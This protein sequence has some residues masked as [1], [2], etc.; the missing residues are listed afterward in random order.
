MIY[1]D[2]V[3]GAHGN[4][5][6]YV[7]N[8]FLANIEVNDSPFNDLGAA[9]NKTYRL[10]KKFE[11]WHYFDYHGIKTYLFNSK[12]VS[13]QSSPD[14]LL[15]LISV[16]LL[17]AA[18]HNLD[19]DMLEID[20][21]NKLNNKNYKHMLKTLI[22]SFFQ[23]TR[24]ADYYKIKDPTWPEIYSIADFENLPLLI[25]NECEQVFGLLPPKF[26]KEFPNCPRH[27]LREFFKIG[28][29]NPSVQGIMMEQKKMT[30]DTTNN[31]YIFPYSCFYNLDKFTNEIAQLA[32]WT[33]YDFVATD[34]FKN[35]HTEFL[36][37][38][39]YKNSKTK[40]DTL[41]NR[42]LSQEH[43]VL[44]KLTLL[45]ESYLDAKLES[46]YNKNSPT[47]NPQWFCSSSEILEYFKL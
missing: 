2:F 14:D 19:N 22:D 1:I 13:I 20:T 9:H 23:D 4:Y 38:Q 8:R 46:H 18:D 41:L 11:A 16:S 40:C 44:P 45:E 35:L 15:T 3:G 36:D 6:E 33:G 7:C 5:L 26:S 28:F 12:I 32:A 17:R 29:C 39:I 27:I 24:I 31:V 34:Q 30:Y 47:D 42:I 37:K 10:P 43:F 21:F 25:K